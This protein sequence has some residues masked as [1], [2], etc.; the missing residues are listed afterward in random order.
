MNFFKQ[1]RNVFFWNT[2]ISE[3]KN[4]FYVRLDAVLAKSV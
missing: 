3:V 1:E 2:F 4:N